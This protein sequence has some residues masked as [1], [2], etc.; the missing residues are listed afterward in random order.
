METTS[1]RLWS[2]PDDHRVRTDGASEILSE[3]GLGTSKQ[4]LTKWRCV[5]GGP[6]FE[7]YGRIPVYSMK[8]LRSFAKE[9]LGTPVRNTG[10]RRR[11]A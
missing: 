6:E 8:S 10:Q 4:T 9:R 5:G 11:A 2:L 1:L 3:A 7:Y